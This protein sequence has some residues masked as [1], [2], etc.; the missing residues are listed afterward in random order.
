M[1]KDCVTVSRLG[2]RHGPARRLTGPH[3]LTA[4]S[5]VSRRAGQRSQLHGLASARNESAR[6]VTDKAQ[7]ESGPDQT[8]QDSYETASNGTGRKSG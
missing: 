4:A 5:I 7:P 2:A 8:G 6:Q 1:V 3:R